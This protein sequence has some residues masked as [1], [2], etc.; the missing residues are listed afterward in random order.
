IWCP[1]CG[2]QFGRA[3]HLERHLLTHTNVKPFKCS[4][5]H[6][7]FARK[8][9]RQRHLNTIHSNCED[10]SSSGN[11]NAMMKTTERN[12]IACENCARTKTKCDK[13][14]P[15]SRCEAKGLSCRVRAARRKSKIAKREEQNHQQLLNG[16]Q[17]ASS[18]SSQEA[19]PKGAEGSP[20]QLPPD[21]FPEEYGGSQFQSPSSRSS[22]VIL[23]P[24]RGTV[25][26]NPEEVMVATA[27]MTGPLNYTPMLDQQMGPW[28]SPQAQFAQQQPQ[29]FNPIA[30]PDATMAPG[31]TG[32]MGPFFEAERQMV[33]ALFSGYSLGSNPSLQLHTPLNTPPLASPNFDGIHHSPWPLANDSAY[34]SGGVDHVVEDNSPDMDASG[35]TELTPTPTVRAYD[36]WNSFCCHRFISPADC[37][38]TAQYNLSS[39]QQLLQDKGFWETWKLQCPDADL[40]NSQLKVAPLQ[41]DARDILFAV[42]QKSFRTASKRRKDG[43][44][45][46]GS[47]TDLKFAPL[48]PA[49]VLERFLELYAAKVER[50]F[51]MTPLGCLDINRLLN[52]APNS[53]LASILVL[54]MV[55]TGAL[56]TQ[57]IDARLLSCGLTEAS[58]VCLRSVI[59]KDIR[60]ARSPMT[61]HAGLL[62]IMSAA[63]SGDKWLMDIAIGQRGMYL[64]MM[65]D[66]RVP[67]S[68]AVS[69]EPMSR[70]SWEHWLRQEES[71]RLTYSWCILDLELALFHDQQPLMTLDDFVVPMPT[72]DSLWEATTEQQWG[73][74]SERAY[75]AG[76]DW[77]PSLGD[78]FATLKEAPHRIRGERLTLLQLRLL[79]HPIL[80]EVGQYRSY[81]RG[82]QS[83]ES[84][85][86]RQ[87]CSEVQ[88]LLSQWNTLAAQH[89]EARGS[90]CAIQST[91]AL[92]QLISLAVVSDIKAIEKFSRR[93]HQLKPSRCLDH[94]ELA[95]VH[96]C[97]V[98]RHIRL[99]T[100]SLRPH[101]WAAAVYRASMTIWF[102]T[103]M[104]PSKVEAPTSPS[105]RF[106]LDKAHMGEAEVQHFLHSKAGGPMIARQ[107]GVVIEVDTPP[108]ALGV[109]VEILDEGFL[110]TFGDGIRFKLVS[111]TKEFR[112]A[113]ERLTSTQDRFHQEQQRIHVGIGRPRE[114]EAWE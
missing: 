86:A 24:R 94:E 63:W 41:E 73:E 13:S 102:W 106:M 87:R 52:R 80:S 104:L 6:M 95:V 10:T 12:A 44:V 65:R 25:A 30:R 37:P 29:P 69:A 48:P 33:P 90:S 50:H 60:L 113:P 68:T 26:S 45:D 31:M 56:A 40:S 22:T 70:L 107:D 89:I 114:V 57:S 62:F 75:P 18:N 5:C 35:S 96:A 46:A 84:G 20:Q 85:S 112:G 88:T 55:A 81:L 19:L 27:A 54:L 72:D 105:G 67:E 43:N 3:E 93:P 51:P 108:L 36:G 8:D 91:L 1:Y 78:L 58:R 59:E 61:H 7:S 64:A 11:V 14:F 53:E 2:N 74:A 111:M 110:N 100:P 39:L 32:S 92:F 38:S 34:Y 71:S 109:G 21:T 77:P 66:T 47:S 76:N 97:Q 28:S 103:Y 15:C 16:V 4:L 99:V 49:R 42:T 101:W 83:H 79:L 17:P 98:L 23:T 9:L 82:L